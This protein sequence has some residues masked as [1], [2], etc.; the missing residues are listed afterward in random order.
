MQANMHRS[1]TDK[2]R[3]RGLKKKSGRGTDLYLRKVH[4]ADGVEEQKKKFQ[5]LQI[6][7][8]RS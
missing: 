5:A 7:N 6:E 8:L 3:H 4:C 2:S 1:S